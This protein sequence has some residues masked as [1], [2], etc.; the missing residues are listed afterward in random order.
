[1][2]GR[3]CAPLAGGLYVGEA[4]QGVPH[5]QASLSWLQRP[6]SAV[7]FDGHMQ[8]GLRHGKKPPSRSPKA[9]RRR[10]QQQQTN[11]QKT[12]DGRQF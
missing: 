12:D 2:D 10:H 3:V 8:D 7:T 9:C 1:M 11:S 5:G 6:K 4:R